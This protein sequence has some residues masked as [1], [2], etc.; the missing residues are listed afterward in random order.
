MI[1]RPPRS[2]L[3]PYTTLFRSAADVE[4]YSRLMG[5]DEADTMRNLAAH[6]KIMDRLITQHRGRIANTAGDSVLAEFP[7]A[8]DAVQCAVAVQERLAEAN[9]RFVEDRRVQFRIG[10]HVG[11]GMVRDG[12]LLGGAVNVTAR[13]QGLGR[14]GGVCVSGPAYDYVRK[15]LPLSFDDLGLQIVK[16]I[17]EPVPAYAVRSTKQKL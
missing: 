3:F 14:P 10:V 13:L 8:V 9:E 15:V 11:G 17:A 2:T 4:G 16:S 12:D 1:R 6:R 7:S 5:L